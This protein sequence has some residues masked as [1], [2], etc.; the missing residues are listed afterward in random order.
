MG[1]PKPSHEESSLRPQPHAVGPE[2]SVLSSLLKEPEQCFRRARELGVTEASFYLPGHSLL[3]TELERTGSGPGETDLVALV[4][5]LSDR[6]LLDAIGGPASLTDIYTY[7]PSTAAFD[8]HVD[9]LREK[10]VQRAMLRHFREGIEAVYENPTETRSHLE[11]VTEALRGLTAIRGSVAKTL[12]ERAGLLRYDAASVP[13]GE[14]VCLLLGDVPVAARGNLTVIQGKSKV[15]KSAVVSAI[16]GA[17]QV[18]T[19]T[20]PVDCLGFRWQGRE[21][22]VRGAILHLD[23]EQSPADWHALVTRGARRAGL[24]VPLERLISLPLVTFSRGERLALLRELLEH[25]RDHGN[26]TEVLIID[27]VADL[28]ISP[29]DEAEGLELVSRLMALAQEF[30]IAIILIIHENP[31]TDTAKTRGHLGSELNRKAFA[32]LRIDK[33]PSTGLSVIYGTDMRKRDIPQSHG[34]CF[35]WDDAARMHIYKGRNAVMKAEIR[36]RDATNR[37]REEWER[38]FEEKVK[39][40]GFHFL[41]VRDAIE[42]E[43]DI[44]GKAEPTTETTMKKRLQRGEVLG[45]LEKT[46]RGVYQLKPKGKTG[47]HRESE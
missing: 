41:T 45:I 9:I 40:D 47:H 16:L 29:N 32:N 8:R 19:A 14:E 1:M 12:R 17:V 11:R 31:G 36:E 23:T 6:G 18:S 21:E 46:A 7:A 43:R 4:N 2:K 20:E 24:A 25:E 28:C 15:G 30:G 3:F 38:I 37:A 34:F 42:L 27:G 39:I 5:S 22:A 35:G 33:D 10:E 26:G 13:P 44:K